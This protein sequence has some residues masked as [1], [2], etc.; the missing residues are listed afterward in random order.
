[1]FFSFLKS[2][3]HKEK[4][5]RNLRWKTG[6][7]AISITDIIYS[8]CDFFL[9]WPI[10]FQLMLRHTV[11]VRQSWPPTITSQFWPD[12]YLVFKFS[13]ISMNCPINGKDVSHIKTRFGKASP[14]ALLTKSLVN[15]DLDFTCKRCKSRHCFY[16]CLIGLRHLISVD[17][18]ANRGD[19]LLLI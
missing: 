1:M 16:L 14:W 10:D 2:S 18:Y 3:W 15:K 4:K 17:M 6:S 7:T 13:I 5:E 11:Q 19:H 9:S 8:V 12:L